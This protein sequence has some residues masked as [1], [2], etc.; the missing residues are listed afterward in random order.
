LTARRDELD[1]D[2]LRR[3]EKNPMRILD[4]K[5]PGM[6]RVIAGAPDMHD[7]LD[8]GSRTHFDRLGQHLKESGVA[9]RINPRLVRG[10]DYYTRTVF[11]WTA[12]RL[13]AQSTVCAGG[14]YD[15][16]VEQLGGR[17]APAAGFAIGMERLVELLA[18][19]NPSPSC[20]VPEA[21]LVLLG[22]SAGRH[23]L[24]L[25][26]S[27]RNAGL[28]IECHCG[29]GGLKAQLKRANRRGA[30]FAL[31]LGDEEMRDKTVTVKDMRGQEVQVSVHQ[32]V[33][34]DFLNERTGRRT[35]T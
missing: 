20:G 4:S 5:N 11:E 35:K 13:G 19:Q 12:D 23:G 18:L 28:R 8:A 24:L 25:A 32:D 10:L 30:R 26:E 16:L 1:E 27:L 3:L 21:Y 9:Y 31:M 29:G 17:P 6:Q 14:R 7:H 22:E 2:S 34:I 33:L 15:G